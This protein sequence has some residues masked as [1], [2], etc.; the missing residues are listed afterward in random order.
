MFRKINFTDQQ[1][2]TSRNGTGII[3]AF[4]LMI[5]ALLIFGISG[6]LAAQQPGPV[7]HYPGDGTTEDVVRGIAGGGTLLA[8]SRR[9]APAT[10]ACR[11]LPACRPP[12]RHP[13]AQPEPFLNI[14]DH[15]HICIKMASKQCKKSNCSPH[16]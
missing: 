10:A 8:A 6:E 1:R 15:R 11:L 9:R 12:A 13:P 14:S 4:G 16:I 2:T 5:L 3:K 7:A